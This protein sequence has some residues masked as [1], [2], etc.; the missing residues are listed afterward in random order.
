MRFFQ[1]LDLG[2]AMCHWEMACNELGLNGSWKILEEPPTEQ[3][4][5]PKDCPYIATWVPADKWE[6]KE[7]KKEGRKDNDLLTK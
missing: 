2:I 7:G 1:F 3:L 6:R 5:A 4:S